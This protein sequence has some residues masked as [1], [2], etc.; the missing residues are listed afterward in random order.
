MRVK[1]LENS[2]VI[3]F[4]LLFSSE[5]GPGPL[6]QIK[7]FSRFFE[8]FNEKRFGE[9]SKDVNYNVLFV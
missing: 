3:T 9:K 4:A 7:K 1:I 2:K 8:L 6:V 5:A